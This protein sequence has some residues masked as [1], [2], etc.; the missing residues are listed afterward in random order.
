MIKRPP[1]QSVDKPACD[2]QGLEYGKVFA[3]G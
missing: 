3:I 1:Y 2:V